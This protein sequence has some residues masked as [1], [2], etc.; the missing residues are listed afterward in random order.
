M[1]QTESLE[2]FKKR[3]GIIKKVPITESKKD[4]YNR[5]IKWKRTRPKESK[6]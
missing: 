6:V 2:E 1:T 5:F 3:G 4:K